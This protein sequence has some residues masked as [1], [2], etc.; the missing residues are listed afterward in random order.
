MGAVTC[1]DNHENSENQNEY[2]NTITEAKKSSF[3]CRML[4]A[5]EFLLII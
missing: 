4:S 5:T 1:C 2:I 3:L